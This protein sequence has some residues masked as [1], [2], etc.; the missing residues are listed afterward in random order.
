MTLPRYSF[1]DPEGG[2][3]HLNPAHNIANYLSIPGLGDYEGFREPLMKV[4]IEG[5]RIMFWEAV[6]INIYH[7]VK[8]VDPE[9]SK[10]VPFKEVLRD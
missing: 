2:E 7:L 1:K 4:Q 8:V 10:A 3:V 6:E 9:P 5:W